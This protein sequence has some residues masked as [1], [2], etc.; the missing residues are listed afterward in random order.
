MENLLKMSGLLSQED[1]TA[2][3]LNTIEQRL[4]K[5]TS[6]PQ[7]SSTESRKNSLKA[8]SNAPTPPQS[9]SMITPPG[10]VGSPSAQSMSLADESRKDDP[11]DEHEL[12]KLSDMMCTLMTNSAGET[13]F[14][15]R[16]SSTCFSIC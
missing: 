4:A 15:G 2:T 6:S 14:L 7:D 11:S 9:G 10:T 16:S 8:A 13:R 3:D 12:N 5:R 1:L